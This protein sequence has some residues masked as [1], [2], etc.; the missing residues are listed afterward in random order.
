M[1]S[2]CLGACA[3][4]CSVKKSKYTSINSL[5]REMDKLVSINEDLLNENIKLKEKIKKLSATREE[6]ISKLSAD[7]LKLEK[8]KHE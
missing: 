8:N 7:L 4:D 1:P 5:E 2:D 3:C 6:I